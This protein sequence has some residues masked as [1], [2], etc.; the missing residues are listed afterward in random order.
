MTV[1][2]FDGDPSK[3]TSRKAIICARPEEAL[4]FPKLIPIRLGKEKTFLDHFTKAGGFC[5]AFS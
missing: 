3:D 4:K 2:L 1:Y 5:L